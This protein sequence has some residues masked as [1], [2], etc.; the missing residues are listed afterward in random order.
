MY[1][2]IKIRWFLLLCINFIKVNFVIKIYL[3]F[4]FRID[5][6]INKIGKVDFVSKLDLLKG[7]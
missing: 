1:F 6:C 5:D 7:Y 2:C 4:I 3:Y